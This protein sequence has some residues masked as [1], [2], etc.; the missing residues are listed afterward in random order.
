MCVKAVNR[1][2][3]LRNLRSH[4]RKICCRTATENHDVNLS[5]Q[6]E[7]I[8]Q[9]YFFYAFCQNLNTVRMT[10]C[11]NCGQFHI[12]ISFNGKFY[13]ASDVSIAYDT[14]SN[15]A[16]CSLLLYVYALFQ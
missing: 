8:L 10:A 9:T 16:H 15:F 4:H 2:K 13:A 11:H 12:F 14:N 6:R 5:F 3:V 1:I 7:H